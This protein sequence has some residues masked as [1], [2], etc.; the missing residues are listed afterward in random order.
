MLVDS[1]ERFDVRGLGEEEARE[2]G[3]R[4]GLAT[5]AVLVLASN[6]WRS[7]CFTCGNEVGK[8]GVIALLAFANLPCCGG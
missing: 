3:K 4:R 7:C 5:R 6:S 1:H 2:V 8:R